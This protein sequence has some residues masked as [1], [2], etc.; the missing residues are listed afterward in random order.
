MKQKSVPGHAMVFG[1]PTYSYENALEGLSSSSAISIA[2][3]INNELT[4][5]LPYKENQHRILEM[6]K[7]SYAKTQIDLLDFNLRRLAFSGFRE[8]AYEL[9]HRR[10]L[11]S[12]LV[13][14]LRRNQQGP[15]YT[16]RA[17]EEFPFLLAYL[18]T[19]DDEHN[20]DRGPLDNSLKQKEDPFIEY[21]LIWAPYIRQ[22]QFNESVSPLFELF[23]MI[24]LCRY[25][26]KNW[27][28]F[29][30]QFLSSYNLVSIGQLANS[31]NQVF[32]ALLLVNPE[33]PLKKLVHIKPI[34]NLPALHL[35]SLCINSQF[36]NPNASLLDVKKRPLIQTEDGRYRVI[37]ANFFFKHT[38]KGPFFDLVK[39]TGLEKE[40]GF[41]EY[42]KQVSKHVIEEVCFKA[43]LE[44]LKTKNG[45][46]IH[47][48]SN[49]SASDG[50]FRQDK[51]ILLMENKAYVLNDSYAEQPDF[52]KLKTYI[53]ENFI[54][55]QDGKPKGAG[56]LIN[57]LS[58]LRDGELN[59]DA[60]PELNSNEK[61]LVYPI[62]FHNDF[63]FSLPGINEYINTQ[64]LKKIEKNS[65]PNFEIKNLTLINL[66]CLFD[67][68]L[69]RQDFSSLYQLI[70]KY[71][72]SIAVSK[73]SL[74]S[75]FS[76]ELFL[77]S[78]ISFDEMYQSNFIRSLPN[79]AN[80][81]E[82]LNNI[83]EIAGI[84][85]AM[86]DEHV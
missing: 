85:Q 72:E 40:I 71:W 34:N 17:G 42:S 59:S 54:Q 78:K 60:L 62:I 53:D 21:R 11:L 77:N 18:L 12:L 51:V 29:L 4:L 10:Y 35:Q 33:G 58:L 47:E 37:D 20:K 50:Y 80:N 14:E 15:A 9:F 73:K 39:T 79:I 66:D 75:N 49:D 24:S 56:Q 57:Q 25:A 23:K 19:I 32:K 64:F 43:I 6:T 69:R 2:I 38:Y 52:D 30:K 63:Q 26:F 74:N 28:P 86:L 3:A 16:I 7:K 82:R 13:K 46:I 55:K 5:D 68:A 8:E 61:Y 36:G 45:I 22:Y 84:N 67:I 41:N 76:S 65:F 70:D 27:R 48:T 31:Y 44:T 83:L 1:I 81:P